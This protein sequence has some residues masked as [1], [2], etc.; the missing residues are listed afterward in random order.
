MKGIA[1]FLFIPALLAGHSHADAEFKDRMKSCKQL[2]RAAKVM[3]TRRQ[4]GDSMSE[5]MEMANEGT[6]FD[7]VNTIIIEAWKRPRH[8][9]AERQSRAINEFKDDIYRA[10]L[11][12]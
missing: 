3:M 11:E 6:S 5:I 12:G 10:C 7:A 1:V 4:A 9:S 2:E 8:G